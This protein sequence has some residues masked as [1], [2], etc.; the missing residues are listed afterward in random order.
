MAPLNPLSPTI[1]ERGL[2]LVWDF[3][4]YAKKRR[5]FFEL[6]NSEVGNVFGKKIPLLDLQPPVIKICEL[7]PWDIQAQEILKIHRQ[8]FVLNINEF[9]ESKRNIICK[10]QGDFS[11]KVNLDKK[12]I[13][14]PCEI[15]FLTETKCQRCKLQKSAK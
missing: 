10:K 6:A 3:F 9:T 13:T 4:R 15:L 1:R 11:P 8:A 14:Y 7:G 5:D 2:L 12:K